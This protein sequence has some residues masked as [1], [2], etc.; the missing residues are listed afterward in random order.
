ML[1]LERQ[2]PLSAHGCRLLNSEDL[3]QTWRD[4]GKYA[5]SYFVLIF[6]VTDEDHRYRFLCM[7][8]IGSSVGI[9]QYI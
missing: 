9:D 1:I 2:K 8:C 5:F 4:I 3:Q 7:G 6:L